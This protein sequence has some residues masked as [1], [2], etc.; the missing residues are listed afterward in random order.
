MTPRKI[1]FFPLLC[2][3]L[4]ALIVLAGAAMMAPQPVMVAGPQAAAILP[5]SDE[6]TM[7]LADVA[8][9]PIPISWPENAAGLILTIMFS[10]FAFIFYILRR[11]VSKR[12]NDNPGTRSILNCPISALASSS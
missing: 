7:P 4:L 8:I 11:C 6:G 12:S 9:E 10:L 3:I 2:L 1:L 5:A